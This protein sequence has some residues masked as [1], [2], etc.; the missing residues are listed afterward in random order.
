MNI[1]YVMNKGKSG[2][3]KVGIHQH[4]CSSPVTLKEENKDTRHG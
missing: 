1:Y 3:S 2:S 4:L